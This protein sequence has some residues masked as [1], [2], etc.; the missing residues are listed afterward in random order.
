MEYKVHGVY[1]RTYSTKDVI[2]TAGAYGT[3]QIL[4]RSGIG[5]AEMLERSKVRSA[6]QVQIPR[7][8]LLVHVRDASLINVTA[9]YL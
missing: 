7:Y 8:D 3:P 5:P 4:L 6:E 1:Q 2:L 9:S